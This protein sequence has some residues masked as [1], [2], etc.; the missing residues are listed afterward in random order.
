MIPSWYAAADARGVWVYLEAAGGRLEGVSLELLGAAR[1]LAD[2]LGAELVG[3]AAGRGLDAVTHAAIT[4]GAD[5]V[6]V[7]EDDRLGSYSTEPF[8]RVLTD[9]VLARRPSIL[10]LG[11][12]PDGRDLAGRLAV[13]LR[14]GL[15]ADCTGLEIEPGTDVLL[16]HTTGFGGGVTATIKCPVHRPQMATVRPG[17]FAPPRPNARRSGRVERLPVTLRRRDTRVH[18]IERV[19]QAQVDLTRAK[20]V[21]VGGRGVQGDFSLLERLALELGGEVGATRVAVD[22]GWIDRERQIGQTGY[23]TRP[24]LAIVCG[25]SGAMQFTVGIKH[26]GTVVAINTDPEAAIFEDADYCVVDDFRRVLPPLIERLR[27]SATAGNG[28]G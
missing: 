21:V 9:A 6:L 16:G 22:K 8:A 11:A 18:V 5:A 13:R 28:S 20:V 17:V 27:A 14:T 23:V 25:A 24:D 7:A 12:T 2:Q 4:H 26:A 15:T 19:T 3:V 10:L 1:P